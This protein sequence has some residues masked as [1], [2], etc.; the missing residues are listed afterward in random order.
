MSLTTRVLVGLLLGL[1]A[2][3]AISASASPALLAVARGVEP[4]GTLWINAIRMTVI[5]LVVGSLVAG[6]A[7][8]PDPGR[9]GRVGA[10]A[11]AFFLGTLLIGGV[12][13]AVLAPPVF[14]RLPIDPAASEALARG[15]S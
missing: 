6:I 8:A 2:G 5:P 14:A 7:S 15:R 12:F 13:A 11:L 10:R 1:A 9:L 3:L 4:V